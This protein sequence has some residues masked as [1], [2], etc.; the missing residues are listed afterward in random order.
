MPRGCAKHPQ[1]FPQIQSTPRI[2]L[3]WPYSI[4]NFPA[5]WSEYQENIPEVHLKYHESISN[6]FAKSVS[7]PPTIFPISNDHRGTHRVPPKYTQ[8][9]PP[10]LIRHPEYP[11][12][13]IPKLFHG[14]P[15]L[16]SEYPGSISRVHQSVLAM[17]L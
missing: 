5:L 2:S 13:P 15:K 9:V 3:E 16:S 10:M 7:I 14:S 1:R 6:V 11:P 17:N 12:K 8:K 4:P